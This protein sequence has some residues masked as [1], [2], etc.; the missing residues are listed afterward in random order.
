MVSLQRTPASV[1]RFVSFP[2]EPMGGFCGN[3]RVRFGSRLA[4]R[5]IV[6]YIMKDHLPKK[7][8][9]IPRA[10][11]GIDPDPD[12][13]GGRIGMSYHFGWQGEG[14]IGPFTEW[15]QDLQ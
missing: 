5:L 10:A 15:D 1:T 2:Q 8:Q 12:P 4:V 11:L 3:L 14:I 9:V 7:S 13:Q 6:P